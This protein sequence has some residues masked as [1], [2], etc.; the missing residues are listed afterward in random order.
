MICFF[1]KGQTID[2]KWYSEI[3]SN[4]V[5]IQNSFPKGGPYTGFTKKHYN[6]SYLVFFTRVINETGNP[7]ELNVNFSADSIAIP[8]SP[9]TF[10]KLFLP[11]DTMTLD[12]QNLFSYGVTELESF[13]KSTR[14]QR[15][16]NPKEDCLFYVVAIFYQTRADARN[17][18]RGGNRAE[19]VLKGQ[20]LFYR[21]S[22]Q[23]DFLSCGYINFNK[24][25]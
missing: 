2:T 3:V 14:F 21:M 11:P 22:P 10:V 23:I 20:E 8:N 18:H 6:Y 4:G 7:F 9:N 16:I 13:D 24:G 25:H 12:K 19:L 15:I 5:V 1:V 17:Q